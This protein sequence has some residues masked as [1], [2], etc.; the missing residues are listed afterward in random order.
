MADEHE[1]NT[2]RRQQALI[3]GFSM[4]AIKAAGGLMTLITG[5]Y[6]DLIA[7]PAGAPVGSV[8]AEKVAALG[9]FSAG[10]CILGAV[11][12]VL[13]VSRLDTSL[14]KQQE[15]NRRLQAMMQTDTSVSS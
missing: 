6:L 3:G 8:P 2:G 10:F 15:I 1:V 11:L 13:T 5:V 4:F 9:Y 14:A 12:V 7:F